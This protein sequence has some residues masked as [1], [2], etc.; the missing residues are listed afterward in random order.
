MAL[1]SMCQEYVIN[2]VKPCLPFK[3]RLD[4]E[5]GRIYGHTACIKKAVMCMA[6]HAYKQNYS[7]SFI[8]WIII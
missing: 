1:R 6:L 2:I 3:C 7:L 8:L 5:V 4:L